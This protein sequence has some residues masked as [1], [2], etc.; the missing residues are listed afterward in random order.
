MA[1]I[2]AHVQLGQLGDGPVVAKRLIVLHTAK[3]RQILLARVGDDD[4]LLAVR[5]FLLNRL[6]I[7]IVH[8]VKLAVHRDK[9]RRVFGHGEP[10]LYHHI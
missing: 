4:Q 3:A 2:G 7:Q 6:N 9:L 8:F 1:V 5:Q 10:N